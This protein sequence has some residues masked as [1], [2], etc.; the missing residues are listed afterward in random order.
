MLIFFSVNS[1]CRL[2]TFNWRKASNRLAFLNLSTLVIVSFNQIPSRLRPLFPVFRFDLS[3]WHECLTVNLLS[4]PRRQVIAFPFQLHVDLA[5]RA[6]EYFVHA[7]WQ[8]LSQ[9]RL[10]FSTL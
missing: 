8:L 3:G 10:D 5:C 7:S 2:T 9:K 4:H 6:L 1:G